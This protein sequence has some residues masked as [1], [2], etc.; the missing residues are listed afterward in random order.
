MVYDKCSSMHSIYIK[1]TVYRHVVTFRCKH[2]LIVY[3]DVVMLLYPCSDS[4]FTM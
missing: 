3:I 4:L 1:M 2:V